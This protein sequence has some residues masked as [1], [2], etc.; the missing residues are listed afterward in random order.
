MLKR[1]TLPTKLP[2]LVGI[3]ALTQVAIITR[4][5]EETVKQLAKALNPGSFKIVS[6]KSPELFNTTYKD[7]PENWSMKAGLTWI[8]N[9][10]LEIIQPTS[11]RTV[12][13]D[14]L[15]ERDQKAGIEHIYLA[16]QDFDKTRSHYEAMGYPLQQEA[17]L[18]AAGKIGFLPVPALPKFLQ[19]MAARFGYT[20]TQQSLKLDIELAKFPKGVSQRVALR[21]AIPEKWLPSHQPSLFESVPTDAP[22]RDLDAFYVLTKDLETLVA[23][24]AKLTDKKPEITPYYDDHLPGEGHLAQIRVGTSLLVLV[25]PKQGEIASLLSDL[26]EGLTLLRGRPQEDVSTTIRLLTS[27][28]WT[29]HK[30]AST[31]G[32]KRAFAKHPAIPFAL[33]VTEE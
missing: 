8:G 3:T 27:L 20:K 23:A 14:Y 5:T 19:H 21:A 30:S 12:Y 10:Q 33:W 7:K 4:D 22:L 15:N 25:Q 11:G 28:G 24:Y 18:N 26:G 29:C 9:T 17:Q 16:A 32:K 2:T 31:L 13:D 6:A 1:N